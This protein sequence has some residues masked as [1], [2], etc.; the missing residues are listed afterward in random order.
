MIFEMGDEI[1]YYKPMIIELNKIKFHIQKQIYYSDTIT[2]ENPVIQAFEGGINHVIAY[3]FDRF[4]S[5]H[6]KNTSFASF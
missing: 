4:I 1:K 3:A 2:R 5:G 6:M